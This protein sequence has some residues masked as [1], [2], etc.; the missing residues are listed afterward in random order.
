MTITFHETAA[1]KIVHVVGVNNC[2]F[3]CVP[4]S[5]PVSAIHNL[6]VG[7]YVWMCRHEIPG[8]GHMDLRFALPGIN[9]EILAVEDTDIG[10]WEKV[11]CV[12]MSDNGI[13]IS[14]DLKPAERMDPD[15]DVQST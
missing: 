14:Q 10:L 9:W 1:R 12:T 13:D 4:Q 5:D 7:D 8:S 3:E 2:H 6:H 11:N 15:A